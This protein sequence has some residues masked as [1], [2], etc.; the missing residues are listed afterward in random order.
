MHGTIL[1]EVKHYVEVKYGP[2]TWK[3]L[4]EQAGFSKT[5]MFLAVKNYSD[6]DL[7]KII[8]KALEMT[9]MTLPAFLRDLGVF[10]G[11]YLIKNYSSLINPSWGALDLIANTELNIHK[12]LRA[13]DPNMTPPQLTIERLGPKDLII[14]YNSP[15]KMCFLAEGIVEAISKHYRQKITTVQ[16]TCMHKGDAFCSIHLH[17]A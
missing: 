9:K 6:E 15:R 4:L 17:E 16:K 8:N 7:K 12:V 5:T 10:I 3:S 11:N 1:N 13:Q 2:E 14:K